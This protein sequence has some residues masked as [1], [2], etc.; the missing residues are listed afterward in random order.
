MDEPFGSVDAITRNQLRKEIKRIHEET[1]ITIVFVTN[2]ISEA[3][4]LGDKILIINN[5]NIEQYTTPDEIKNK[6][7]TE[8]TRK[9]LGDEYKLKKIIIKNINDIILI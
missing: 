1:N 9:L 7:V 8:F 6:P 2:D 3:L 4:V 5:G